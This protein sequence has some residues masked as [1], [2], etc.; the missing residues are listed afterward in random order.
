MSRYKIIKTKFLCKTDF[1]V[2]PRLENA[3]FTPIFISNKWYDGEY[4]TWGFQQGYELNG[5]WRRY[6]V[7]GEDGQKREMSRPYMRATFIIDVDELRDAKIDEILN[8]N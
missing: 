6:W 4:E 8:K 1:S 2:S 5:G 7:I 3:K